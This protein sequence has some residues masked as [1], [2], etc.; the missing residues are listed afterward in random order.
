MTRTLFFDLD[1]TLTDPRE[2]ILRSLRHALDRLGH[3][4]P[5]DEEL[6]DCIGPPLLDTFRTLVGEE[7][8]PVG[9]AHYRERFADRGWQENRPLEGIS[10]ALGELKACHSV[11]Y[12][13]TSKPRVYAERIVTHFGLGEYFAAVFGAEL[14]GTRADK[15][16][17]LHYAK[18]MTGAGDNAAVIGDRRFDILGGR[19]NGMLTVGVTWGFGSRQ[20]LEA[21]GADL[22]VDEPRALPR[23]LGP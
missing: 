12:V 19:A 13:A 10:D 16:E 15:R 4:C 17:L 1:G 18:R 3:A 11:L 23:V 21:A 8:A 2:G 22:L 14:D 6:T 7:L 20:E 5:P 9:L